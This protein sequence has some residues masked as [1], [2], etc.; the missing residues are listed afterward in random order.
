MF[1]KGMELEEIL[2]AV[3]QENIVNSFRDWKIFYG[4]IVYLGL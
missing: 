1:F 3:K 4:F 2:T